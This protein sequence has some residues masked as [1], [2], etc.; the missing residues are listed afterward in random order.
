MPRGLRILTTSL[1][2]LLAVTAPAAADPLDWFGYDARTMGAGGGGAGVAVSDGAGALHTNPAL[3]PGVKPGLELGYILVNPVLSVR[4]M[5]RPA[6]ADIPIS[7]Y[8]A[9]IPGAGTGIE[10]PLPTAELANPRSDTRIAQ[11]RHALLLSV[12]T[13]LGVE[14]L[15]LAVLLKAP[16]PELANMDFHY[17]DE[18]EQYFSNRLHFVR[19]GEW[20]DMVLLMA[21][22]AWR[23]LRWFSLGFSLKTSFDM[24]ARTHT[25]I[26]DAAVQEYGVSDAEVK[27]KVRFRPVA[28]LAFRPLDW[29]RLGVTWRAETRVRTDVAAGLQLWNY[30]EVPTGAPDDARDLKR[31]TQEFQLVTLFQPHEIAL[32]VG[33]QFD[34]V[35]AEA[36]A[37]LAF[38]SRAPDD[39]GGRARYQD[40]VGVTAGAG[41]RYL[42]W[43]EA[44]LGLAYQ[45][46][47]VP[48][49]TG[50]TSDVDGDLLGLTAGHR[51][52]FLIGKIPFEAGVTVQ[53]W[54]MLDQIVYKDPDGILDEFPDG[55]VTL[56]EGAP[57]PEADGLQT[58]NPGFPGYRSGGWTFVAGGSLRMEF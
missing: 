28:G 2:T 4:L 33:V 12:V 58:N 3:L 50:R 34:R 7:Y 35:F 46:T 42:T 39:H 31:V 38:W 49:Q 56:L 45:P 15:R 6:G 21:G 24:V 48:P 16:V 13:D 53:V 40:V 20:D 22:G 51:F 8:D 9:K 30:H 57:M 29:L 41:W 17:S 10:K 54:R 26:P 36:A 37:T 27:M 44:L 43:A 18:R 55:V 14:D 25:F 52:R 11:A 5:D 47:P 32:G 23:P 19:F 1:A